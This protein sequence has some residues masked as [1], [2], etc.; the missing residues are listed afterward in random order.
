MLTTSIVQQ[1]WT[2]HT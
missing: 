2:L 1:M